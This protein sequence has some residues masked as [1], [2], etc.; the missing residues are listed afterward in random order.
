MRLRELF[1]S[2]R[3]LLP[4]D[5]IPS[6][7]ISSW[8]HER[9]TLWKEL[10]EKDFERLP[11]GGSLYDPFDVDGVNGSI[12][13]AGLLYGSG[14]GLFQKPGFLVAKLLEVKELLDYR[15]YYCGSELCRDLSASPAM[16]QGRCIYL[17]TDVLRAIVWDKFQTMRS[18]REGGLIEELFRRYK[19][20][21]APAA[22]G[23][24]Y[25]TIDVMARGISDLFVLHE[26]GEAFEDD[27]SDEWHA[28]LSAGFD[29]YG[30]LYLRAVKDLLADTSTKGPLLE[31][32]RRKDSELLYG[33]MV[34]L[35]GIRK[36]V[37]PEIGAAF[38][39]FSQDGD[40][41][42]IENAGMSGYSRAV[43][44]RRTILE[45]WGLRRDAGDG[46]KTVTAF[47]RNTF[48]PGAGRS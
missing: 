28:V 47:L 22:S 46:V 43:Q 2:E 39:R 21:K 37:F 44:L 29:K 35:E 17:R 10:E 38:R 11:A 27:N 3:G 23:G 24:L 36:E 42:E 40:W 25:G 16:L 4:W 20:T 13:N 33:Y 1:R 6:E 8:I 26:V 45:L 12:G 14:Y 5:D 7:E 30:E 9:E 18:R 34:F 31:I 32:V 41:A 19:I 48:S 15:I